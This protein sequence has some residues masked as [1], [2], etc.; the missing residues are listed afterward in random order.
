MVTTC[1]C[2]LVLV[3]LLS[4]PSGAASSPSILFS[5]SRASLFAALCFALPLAADW[6]KPIVPPKSSTAPAPIASPTTKTLPGAIEAPSNA[7]HTVAGLALDK[8]LAGE[9][10]PQKAWDDKT[11]TTDDL[12]WIIQA[13]I[14]AWG[15]FYWN[16]NA[17][18]RRELVRL[19]MAHGAEKLA[20]PEKLSPTLRLWLADYYQGINDEKC[21]VLCES[22]LSEIKAP[23]KGENVLVFQTLERAAWFYA[24]KNENE[25]CGQA[26]LM[27]R[28]R[29]SAS[30]LQISAT[31]LRRIPSLFLPA[32]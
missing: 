29:S 15:G 32:P 18:L 2:F 25:K 26:W 21:L 27:N 13:R 7:G 1:Q 6:P 12:L 23:L 20:A 30:Y 9:L 3:R 10:T 19:L 31:N 14:D 17:P 4:K 16:K 11:I 22:I 8:M 24:A 5:C 28:T